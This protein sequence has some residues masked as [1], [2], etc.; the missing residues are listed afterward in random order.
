MAGHVMQ[1]RMVQAVIVGAD[2]VAANGDT[3]N[4]IGTYSLAVLARYHS[5]PLYIA[6]PL[7]TIDTGTASGEGIIIE[8]RD[9]AEVR[10]FRGQM[11]A[12]PQTAVYNPAFD[13]TPAG[14]ITAI[15][16]EEKIL[17]PP[18]GEGISTLKGLRQK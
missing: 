8:E 4:K 1:K 13:V 15:I 3:A 7:S 5:I 2:R 6:A 17:H 11:T 9:P 14:L 18:Y 10:N 12:R 16:T